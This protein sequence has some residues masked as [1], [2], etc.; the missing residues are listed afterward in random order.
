MYLNRG[1]EY[2]LYLTRRVLLEKL[3][4]KKTGE[5]GSHF[6]MTTDKIK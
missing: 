5:G 2:P 4:M 3:W 6:W 1:N